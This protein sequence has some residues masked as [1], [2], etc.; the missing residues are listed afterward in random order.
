VG[1]I[2]DE[3]C[4]GRIPIHRVIHWKITVRIMALVAIIISVIPYSSGIIGK[5]RALC[6]LLVGMS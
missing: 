3:V 6:S 4:E 1:A 5:K 2:Y